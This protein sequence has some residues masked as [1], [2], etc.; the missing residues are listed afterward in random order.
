MTVSM[1]AAFE[2]KGLIWTDY[3]LDSKSNIGLVQK[4]LRPTRRAGIIRSVGTATR[5]PQSRQVVRKSG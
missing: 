1:L 5:Y 2:T 3:L 4:P